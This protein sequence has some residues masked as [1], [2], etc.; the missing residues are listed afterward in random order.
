MTVA[1]RRA[2]QNL[3]LDRIE[4]TVRDHR[5]ADLSRLA[6]RLRRTRLSAG[7][8]EFRQFL[9]EEPRHVGC[10]VHAMLDALGDH[11]PIDA[12]GREIFHVTVE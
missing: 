4:G 12:V 6:Q 7:L 1:H 2:T 9:I 10:A 3:P 11:Q 8:D 5:L